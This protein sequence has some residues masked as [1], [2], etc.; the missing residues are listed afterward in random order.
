MRTPT[1]LALLTTLMACTPGTNT[2]SQPTQTALV[3]AAGTLGA[4]AAKNST[5]ATN[6]VTKGLAI[7]GQIDSTTGELLAATAV[8]V[9]TM[10]GVPTSVTGAASN[11][12]AATCS[13]LTIA[14]APAVPGALPST[15][16]AASLPVVVVATGLPG[17]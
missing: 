12:V 2:V 17:S 13:A 3:A 14:G 8:G 9:L 1:T 11:T 10:A 7:C 6:L 4:V 16:A 15:L 5:T